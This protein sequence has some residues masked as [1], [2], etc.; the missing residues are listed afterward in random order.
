MSSSHGE[1]QVPQMNAL[2]PKA[3][4]SPGSTSSRSNIKRSQSMIPAQTMEA[5]ANA[6]YSPATFR[7][8]SQPEELKVHDSLH[9][10]DTVA[11]SSPDRNKMNRLKQ[12]REKRISRTNKHIGQFIRVNVIINHTETLDVTVDRSQTV[13]YLAHQI[14]A[15]YAFRSILDNLAANEA[16][17][18]TSKVFVKNPLEIGQLYNSGMLAL[19][20]TDIIGD[21][22]EFNDTI[23]VV[24]TYE[25]HDPL[26]ALKGEVALDNDMQENISTSSLV[27]FPEKP[28]SRTA[29]AMTNQTLDDRL[30]MLLHN[31]LAFGIF[32][33]F[34][35]Q[36]YT[37]ENLL[38]WL[39]VE[40]FQGCPPESRKTFGKN[41][42]LVYIANGS[43]L[44]INLPNEVRSDLAAVFQ[45]DCEVDLSVFDEAQQNVYAMIKGHTFVRFEKSPMMADQLNELKRDKVRYAQGRISTSFYDQFPVDLDVM[46][47]LNQILEDPSSPESSA[48]LVELGDGKPMAVNSNQFRELFLIYAVRQ[49][50]PNSSH[51]LSSYFD[52]VC[53]MSWAQKQSKMLKE[54]K[55]A[56]FFGERP[57]TEQLQKQV[58]NR[59]RLM[60]M[61]K[62][63][64]PWETDSPLSK[65]DQ[66]VEADGAEPSDGTNRRKK[67]EKLEEFFGDRIPVHQKVQQNLVSGQD[68]INVIVGG[69]EEDDDDSESDDEEQMLTDVTTTNDLAPEERRILKKRNKK[70]ATLLGES[71]DPKAISAVNMAT[72]R[73]TMSLAPPQLQQTPSGGDLSNSS[74]QDKLSVSLTDSRAVSSENMVPAGDDGEFPDTKEIKKKRLDKLS[75]VLGTRIKIDNIN[76]KQ[77]QPSSPVPVSPNSASIG[78]SLPPPRILSTD[79][80]KQV[81]KRANKIERLLG[82]L[83]PTEALLL[84]VENAEKNVVMHEGPSLRAHKNIA[85]LS[86]L[87]E[88]A[89]DVVDLLVKITEIDT[90]IGENLEDDERERSKDTRKKKLNKLRKF[91]GN[92]IDVSGIIEQQLFTELERT[93][94]EEVTDSEDLA[95]L[96]ND[97]E[98]LRQIVQRRSVQLQ[99]DL[100]VTN[101]GGN[102]TVTP[103]N[104]NSPGL[105]HAGSRISNSFLGGSSSLLQTQL[106]RESLTPRS[107]SPGVERKA[108]I[109]KPT[110]PVQEEARR[111]SSVMRKEVWE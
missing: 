91:F 45:G 76:D 104:V 83:P 4:P 87:I 51:T 82:A 65:N 85:S 16:D 30:Q 28:R 15:E 94:T 35:I 98:R 29:S 93:I 53:R 99:H 110:P 7:R 66:T 57:S 13:E 70:L 20:F 80:R 43:P 107:T 74:S 106:S 8:M 62:N 109:A 26:G 61:M 34:C 41:I 27:S 73:T 19:K 105:L 40:T 71:V 37:I 72:N 86:F 23:H 52:D 25:E 60:A 22:I 111:R 67:M 36:E 48:K 54:K 79:E 9:R 1:D 42:Y 24:N 95:V 55:L 56:R 17:G 39:D 88:N 46:H 6:Q 10:S 92:D 69:A 59:T 38:F 63:A 102:Y 11:G 89:N 90:D 14:E 97:M 21:A 3:S 101:E 50:F 33:D 47:T 77:A 32:H 58:H 2:P 68:N 75:A 103:E 100:T 44:Q 78:R 12:V 96:R 81:Q 18:K 108:S 5:E 49:Y 64:N 31:K 84:T